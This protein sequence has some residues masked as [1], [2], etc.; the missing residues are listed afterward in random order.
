M[1]YLKWISDELAGDVGTT[2]RYPIHFNSPQIAP[3]A[4]P[5]GS[6][7]SPTHR[8]DAGTCAGSLHGS[9]RLPSGIANGPAHGNAQA[10]SAREAYVVEPAPTSVK[11]VNFWDF[12]RQIA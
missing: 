6:T 1:I 9:G 3:A 11:L 12:S 5:K 10:A 7:G 2:Q 4:T 8:N